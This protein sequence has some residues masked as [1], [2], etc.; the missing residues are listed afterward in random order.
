[1]DKSQSAGQ[2]TRFLTSM[3]CEPLDE[4]SG[5][6]VALTLWP[7]LLGIVSYYTD[8]TIVATYAFD[9]P[10]PLVSHKYDQMI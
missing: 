9:L 5:C 7:P 10:F 6:R 3:G 8:L 2:P 1:M 4:R